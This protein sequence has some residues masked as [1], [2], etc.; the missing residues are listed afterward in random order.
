MPKI[1]T[2]YSKSHEKFYNE[3]F[4]PSLRNI[5]SKEELPIRACALTE[6]NGSN[7]Y[8][9]REWVQSVVF[10]VDM[11]ITALQENKDGWFIYADSDIQFHKPFVKD[12]ENELMSYD[13]VSQQDEDTL[14]TGFFAIKSNERTTRLLDTIKKNFWTYYNDQIAFNHYKDMIQYK[15]LD[16]EKYYTIGNFFN[17]PDGTHEWDGIT[18]IIPPKNMLL[19]HANYVRGAQRK[20]DLLDLIK[21]NAQ[22]IN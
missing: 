6:V 7:V 9:S 2:I 11:L 21:K 14:C 10:K 5:Y 4:K 19:H 20:M 18:N 22:I 1:Y 13:F 15:G 3:Y 17:N 12:V 8:M 16:K